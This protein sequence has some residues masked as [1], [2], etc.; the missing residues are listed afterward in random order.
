MNDNDKNILAQI[1]TDEQPEPKPEPKPEPDP[2]P[3]DLI[4]DI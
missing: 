3:S 1:A 4:V 2:Q